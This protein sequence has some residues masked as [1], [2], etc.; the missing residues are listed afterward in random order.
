MDLTVPAVNGFTDALSRVVRLAIPP[1]FSERV[2]ERAG[3]HLD[4]PAYL[5]LARLEDE[6]WRVG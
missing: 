3:T 4:Q 1:R 6:A 5:L 2:A